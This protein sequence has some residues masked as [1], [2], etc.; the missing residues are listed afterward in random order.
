MSTDPSSVTDSHGQTTAP[1]AP[2][3]PDQP[4][5]Q[6]WYVALFRDSHQPAWIFDLQTLQFLEVNDAAVQRYGYPRERFLQMT[7]KEI[8]PPEDVPALLDSVTWLERGRRVSGEWRH[9]RADGTLIYCEIESHDFTWT[10]AE[11]NQPPRA[12]RLAVINDVTERHRA[13]ETLKQTISDYRGL[14]ENAHDA[15]LIFSPD[16]ETILDVNQRA[17]AVYGF[18]RAEFIGLKLDSITRNPGCGKEAIRD[19]LHRGT[20]QG[21]QS[22]HFRKDGTEMLVEIN[23]AVVTYKGR[24]AILII[25]R[26]QTERVRAEEARRK[27]EQRLRLHVEQT[28]LGVI[29]WDLNFCVSAWNAG[30][31]RIFGFTPAEATGKCARDLIVPPAA[32]DHVEAIWQAL[33]NATGGLRSANENVTKDGRV[34]LCEWYNTPLVDADGKV[35]GVA[36]LVQDVTVEQRA[37]EALA[38]SEHKFRMLAEA[39]VD[40]V[41]L[42]SLDGMTLYLSPSIERL[43]GDKPEDRVGRNGFDF[44]HPDDL[45]LVH[46]GL[47]DPSLRGEPA[48]QI[49]RV[50]RRDGSYVWCEAN[51]RVLFDDAGRPSQVLSCTRD[52]TARKQMEDDL[53]RRAEEVDELYRRATERL[54]ELESAKP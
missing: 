45:E 35:V 20:L 8:G 49:F 53:R 5:D 38:A 36:S 32:R 2:S 3:V 9:L 21:F 11:G 6:T 25:N 19:T 13:E 42:Y 15:I 54:K 46:R 18:S 24:Q 26:D 22:V 29:D 50:R 7:L 12:A 4:A 10:G 40:V 17:C 44:V 31:T 51:T 48:L 14:F 28:P 52:I 23:G 43:T 30:A 27:Q 47:R 1:E 16:D 33:L 39:T 37:H 34:I 41:G